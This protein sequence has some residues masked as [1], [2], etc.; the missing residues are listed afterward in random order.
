V[1]R[2][3]SR[4]CIH[5]H[6]LDGRSRHLRASGRSGCDRRFRRLALVP[7]GGN[8]H[9]AA[10]VQRRQ[11]RHSLSVRGRVDRVPPAGFRE[12]TTARHRVLARLCR[13]LRGCGRDAG[14][15]VRE[16]RNHALCRRQCG[17]RLGQPLRVAAHRGNDAD[18]HDRGDVRRAGGVR[19]GHRPAGRVCGLHRRDDLGRQLPPPCFQRLPV[20]LEDRRQHRLDVL[21][22]SRLRRDDVHGGQ[23]ARPC[24]RVAESGSPRARPD[25]RHVRADR[26]ESSGL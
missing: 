2:E 11:A 23:A 19:D 25:D 20:V 9:L 22:L 26:H 16:L 15:L 17:E 12:R 6:R 13:R 8:H 4:R 14:R 18:Q 24:T 1:A 3:R 21:R 5:R 10:C 7:P